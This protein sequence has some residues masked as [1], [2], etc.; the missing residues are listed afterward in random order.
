MVSLAVLALSACSDAKTHVEA[1]TPQKA[2]SEMVKSDSYGS[3]HDGAADEHAGMNHDAQAETADH[4]TMDHGAMDHKL[5]DVKAVITDT[6]KTEAAKI[7]E[8]INAETITEH[9]MDHAAMESKADTAVKAVT[10]PAE[11]V[12]KNV[13][14]IVD[15]STMDH[16]SMDHGS[17]DH[18]TVEQIVET[19]IA[20]EPVADHSNHAAI[21]H[22]SGPSSMPADGAVLSQSP[23]QIGVNFGHAMSIDS[24]V[25]STLTGETIPLD[26]SGIGTTDH[27][28]VDAPDLQADDYV[29]DW[30]AKGAD[31]HVMSGSFTFT[32]E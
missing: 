31:G 27:I 4:G 21:G 5:P 20:T 26:V 13:E 24:M 10:K 14:D 9:K 22:S 16:G 28:M 15:H 29:V 8:P 12:A 2:D 1:E 11:T 30:R 32:V 7:V 25:I 23:A 3:G 19:S 6:A 17:M 18:G